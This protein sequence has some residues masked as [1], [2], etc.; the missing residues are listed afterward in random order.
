MT[1]SQSTDGTP[2][3]LVLGC[4][5]MVPTLRRFP[6]AYLFRDGSTTIL[7][8][9]GPLTSARMLEYGIGLHEIDAVL[10]SHFH[11]DHFAGT[12]PL[13]HALW[14]DAR[15]SGREA[16]PLLLVG[17]QTIE[18]R[19]QKLREVYWPEPNEAYPL[20]FI[21]APKDSVLVG[22]TKIETFPVKHV[23]WF[24]SIGFRITSCGKTVVYPGDVGSSQPFEELVAQAD[25]A[26]L[27]IVEA[28]NVVPSSSHFTARQVLDLHAAA[29]VK[30]TLVTHLREQHLPQIERELNGHKD[31]RIAID[32]LSIK[33]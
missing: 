13:V 16:R 31:I 29:A 28:G 11:T 19:W 18:Q 21:E 22:K 2:E 12:F 25:R 8:D 3:L 27:L 10:V 15:L 6:S 5:P 17:P 14:V 20:K 4:G 32:G 7:L 30:Q 23:P 26:D 33:L 24:Q 9:C 1:G